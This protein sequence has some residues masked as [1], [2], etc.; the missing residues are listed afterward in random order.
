MK[1][2]LCAELL[3]TQRPFSSN[4]ASLFLARHSEKKIAFV[5]RW[6]VYIFFTGHL[7]IQFSWFENTIL[8]SYTY[9]LRWI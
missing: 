9:I 6:Y 4:L 7:K 8:N 5:S 3:A 2:Y 1:L